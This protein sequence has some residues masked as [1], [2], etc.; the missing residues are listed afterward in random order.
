MTDEAR[1]RARRWCDVAPTAEF[2]A[3]LDASDRARSRASLI[4]VDE[5]HAKIQWSNRFADACARMIA[6]EVRAHRAAARYTVLPDPTGS[7]EPP[8]FV[9]GGV[10]KKVDV[11]V[12]SL[13]SGLQIGISLKGF[14]FRDRRSSNF[15]KNLTGR[16]YELQDELRV[17][18]DY[19]AAA[20]I[21]ALYFMPVAAVADKRGGGASSFAHTV[22]HL[23]ART[24][25][26]DPSLA[27]QRDRADM[28]FVALYSAGDDEAFEQQTSSAR[29][30][31][32]SYTESIRRGVLRFFDVED[33]PPMRGRPQLRLTTDLAGFVDS[34]FVRQ[35]GGGLKERIAYSEP[36][37]D[38]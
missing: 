26:I 11:T 28:A 13:V 10:R 36:E 29:A 24:G 6:A 30:V 14:N 35:R 5:P 18:H 23:R 32:F 19:Q 7:A 20:F 25:R 38:S 31:A 21:V 17:I 37:P 8:I 3:V 12:S 4:N 34:V 9:A 16:T 1:G 22:A 15:D 2:L 33:D 27:S